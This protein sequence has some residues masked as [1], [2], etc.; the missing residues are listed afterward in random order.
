MSRRC[1]GIALTVFVSLLLAVALC[2]QQSDSCLILPFDNRSPDS[3]LDWMGES[4]VE[5]LSTAL[6]DTGPSVLSRQERAAAFEQAGIPL[7]PT[8]SLA[9]RM[10]VAD[11]ADA[12]WLVFGS[13]RYDGQTFRASARVVDLQREHLIDVPEEQGSLQDL[14]TIQDHLAQS[15]L[16]VIDPDDASGGRAQRQHVLLSAYENYIRGVIATEANVRLKYLREAVRLQ[17]DYSHAIFRLGQQYFDGGDSA[18]ALLWLPRVK[19]TDPD[20]WQSQFLAGLAAYD[21]GQ[22]PRAVA[23]FREISNRLPMT[24]VL[25]NFGVA[26]TH[27]HPD[28]AVSVL[29]RAR[30][31]D[32]SDLDVQRNLAAAT[33][34]AGDRAQAAGQLRSINRSHPSPPIAGLLAA[35]QSPAALNTALVLKAEVL[36]PDFPA[37]SFRQLEAT[38]VQFDAK[39]AEALPDTQRLQF[40]LDQGR[41]FLNKGALDGAEKEFRAALDVQAASAPAHLGLAQVFL[42]RH[43]W[44]NA[45]REAQQSLQQSDSVDVHLVLAR[46]FLAEGEKPEA[47]GEVQQALHLD[48]T[49]PAALDLQTQLTGQH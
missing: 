22:Y 40:H 24:Q 16:H 27:T 33:A 25:N 1:R 38:I 4:F 44:N 7:L 10:R 5:S 36:K 8:L 12:H 42:A 15:V 32:P 2:A 34:L 6:Q 31:Q 37:D 21:L 29:A 45:R 17:P 26:L 23:F 28:E 48:P 18:D 47:I 30:Q 46:V 35:V 43:D 9:T 3:S 39:K 41:Q 49:S 20:Y 11:D 19:R 14:Q 13:Y